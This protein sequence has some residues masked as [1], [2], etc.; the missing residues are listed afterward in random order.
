MVRQP[1]T[2]FRFRRWSPRTR[3]TLRVEEAVPGTGDDKVAAVK[4]AK[5]EAL[6][7]QPRS[8]GTCR[9][10]GNLVGGCCGVG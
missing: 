6:V 1:S 8:R 2:N 9:D 10:R 5:G 4:D 7:D 3:R